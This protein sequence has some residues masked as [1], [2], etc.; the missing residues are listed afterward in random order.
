MARK[1]QKLINYHSST[2]LSAQTKSEA[3]IAGELNYGEITVIHAP[4]QPLIGTKTGENT[5]AWFMSSGQVATSIHDAITG[6][7]GDISKL[8]SDVRDLSSATETYINTTAPNTYLTM[9]SAATTYYTSGDVETIYLAKSAASATYLTMASAETTYYTSGQVKTITDGLNSGITQNATDIS[10]L[11]NDVADL[12]V[13][14]GKVETDYSTTAQMNNAIA[15]ASAASVNSAKSYV[16]TVIADYATSA[17]VYTAI[18]GETYRAQG[19]EADHEGRITSLEDKMGTIT[20]ESGL[21]ATVIANKEKLDTLDTTY[22]TKE[23]ATA[24][25][26]SAVTYVNTAS[27]NIET[28]LHEGYWDSATTKN[29]LDTID[30]HIGD[31]SGA[32][33]ATSAAVI[34]LSGDV[35]GYVDTK[36]SS[37]Y[38]YKGSVDYVSGL[39]QSDQVVGD[40]YNVV[41]ANG[42]IG[43]ADYT[44]AGTNYAWNGTA[45]DAL[46][47]TIDLSTYATKDYV[48]NK[49]SGITDMETN[50]SNLQRDL[51]T[52]SGSVSG[53]SGQVV[54]NYYTKTDA[55][56][57]FLTMDSAATTYYTSGDVETIY[58]AKSAAAATYLTIA[59]ATSRAVTVDQNITNLSSATVTI[60]GKANESL[61]AVTTGAVTAASTTGDTNASGVK[62]ANDNEGRVATIDFS[63][64]IVDC[65]DY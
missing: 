28:H 61:S 43:D 59:S 5:V 53:F 42:N 10:Q 62:I 17:N 64:L 32:V 2:I 16:D 58:L 63:E 26:N 37:V 49:T 39:P 46:G 29:K 11:K 12:K 40:V 30:Q 48:D 60:E 54:E 51:G 3:T 13:F 7:T 45:W 33:I 18:S 65:G 6:A 34:T 1:S 25:Y 20:G 57:K 23:D 44:P 24:K 55:D 31:V 47:G 50:I 41:N 21:S 9:Q 4:E 56:A 52:L 19:V 38:R 14:S 15:A 8:Q 27:G 36:V 22:E 35:I